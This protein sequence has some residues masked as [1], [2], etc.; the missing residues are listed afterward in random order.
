MCA[1]VPW[2]VM[3][4][5]VDPIVTVDGDTATQDVT[6]LVFSR[7]SGPGEK[8]RISSTGRYVDILVRTPDG[9]LFSSRQCTLDGWPKP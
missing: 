9:W 8:P 4:V 3:H 6:L 7:P 2:G 5:T 1:S